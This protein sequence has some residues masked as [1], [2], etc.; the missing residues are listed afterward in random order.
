MSASPMS[1]V[2]MADPNSPCIP[3]LTSAKRCR[4]V[5]KLSNAYRNDIHAADRVIRS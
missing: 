2:S 1:A 4:T 3:F 5:L